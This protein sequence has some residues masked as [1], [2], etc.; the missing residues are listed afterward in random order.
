MKSY[1]VKQDDTLKNFTDN[2]CA[3]ASFCFRALLKAR[4]IRVNGVRV[5]G[6]VPLKAGDTV[7]YYM[8]A[9]QESKAAF[10]IVYEDENI[11][12]VDKESGVNSEAVF[13]ALCE[14]GAYSFIH[15]LDRNT[16]GLMVFARNPQSEEELLTA[17]RMR[18]VEKIYH[19]VVK[20]R[21]KNR[22]AVEE[23]Y[24]LKDECAATVKITKD[25]GEKIITEYEILE[26]RGETAL[27]RVTL[28]T[29]K[30]HQIRAHLAY[31]SLPVLGDEKYGD[32][33]FNKKYHATRQRLIA[34]ELVLHT[35]GVLAYLNGKK[36]VSE[37]SF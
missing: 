9:A 22:H 17:F 34:K 33:A 1:T 3:Q 36:F 28:H 30:T 31:L 10:Y 27:L 25:R 12:V 16:A 35:D 2:V 5:S 15:R 37:K 24:L 29:G 4:D 11:A 21:P 14:R 20:G 13:S 18:G 19:A 26:E 8:S 23:A 32:S 7:C 6:D